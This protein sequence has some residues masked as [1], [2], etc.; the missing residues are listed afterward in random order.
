MALR[1]ERS[2]CG[3]GVPGG[4]SGRPLPIGWSGVPCLLV[5]AVAA[6][7]SLCW[8]LARTPHP[9]FFAAAAAELMLTGDRFSDANDL[10][11][12]N[13]LCFEGSSFIDGV[14]ESLLRVVAAVEIEDWVPVLVD[15]DPDC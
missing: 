7:F 1:S 3:S 4:G 11:E 12:P 5:C 9:Q 2:G 13:V 14:L 10:M 8:F 15:D 6:S